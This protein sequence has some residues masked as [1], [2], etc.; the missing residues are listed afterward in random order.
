VANFQALIFEQLPK[1]MLT[2]DQ[3]L[4][5]ESDSIVPNG[6]A[7]LAELGITPHT[8]DAI[9]PTYLESYRKGGRWAKIK[10]AAA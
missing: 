6:A 4:L 1:P 5:L 7:G 10:D 3:I 8:L 9:L 2:R